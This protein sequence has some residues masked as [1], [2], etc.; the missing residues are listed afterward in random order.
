MEIVVASTLLNIDND[1]A[2][3]NYAIDDLNKTGSP[4]GLYDF[5]ESEKVKFY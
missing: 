3:T 2:L 4:F 5:E 1:L